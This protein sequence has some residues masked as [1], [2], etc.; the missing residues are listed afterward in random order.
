MKKLLLGL[1]LALPIT[2]NAAISLVAVNSTQSNSAQ[3]R[4][5][6]EPGT[7]ADGDVIFVHCFATQTGTVTWTD[8][9]DFTEINQKATTAGSP[10]QKSYLGYKVRSGG[11]GQ[12]L[13]FSHADTASQ[14]A[15]TQQWYRGVDNASPLDVTFV[16]ASHYKQAAQNSPNT[17]AAAITTN[18]ANSWVILFQ[19]GTQLITGASGPPSGYT[20]DNDLFGTG[21]GLASRLS[22][23]AHK[24][25]AAAGTETPGV[26]THTDTNNTADTR[27]YTIAL[28]AAAAPTFTGA[29]SCS[30]A[31]NGVSCTYTASAASTAYGVGVALGDGAPTCTQIIAGQNDGGTAALATGSDANT[32][33]ADTIVVTG[34]NPIAKMDYYFC[35]SNGGGNSAV[36]SSQSDKLRTARTG[37]AIVTMASHS[38]TGICNEDS[39]FTPDCADPDVFEYEDDT[40]ESADC[41]VSIDTAGD[42]T[43][44]PVVAG[45]CDGRQTFEISYE[46]ASSATTGLFTAPTTGTF[47]TDDTVYINNSAPVCDIQEASSILLLTEDVAM[48]AIDLVV[49]GDCAD[50]DA[51]ALTFTEIGAGTIPTGTAL[52]GTGN[53]DWT[54]TPSA[55]D[56]NGEALT[57]QACDIAGDCDSFD[58]TVYVV[59]TWVVPDLVG[60]TQAAAE[61]AVIAAAPWRALDPGVA[62]IGTECSEETAGTITDQ[63]PDAAAT[64]TGSQDI[65]VILAI[66]CG[67]PATEKKVVFVVTD[68]TGL[69]RWVDYIPVS[70]VPGCEAGRYEED[71]CWAT[72]PLSSTTGKTAWVDYIPVGEVP[73]EP[74]GKWRYENDGWIPVDDLVP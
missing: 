21:L 45:D 47:A 16:E 17:S 30:A 44:T 52:S 71:G 22:Y 14:I 33:S 46:D 54:G 60:S 18:S 48:T 1:I 2:A 24:L 51:D 26:F 8:P 70:E 62:V 20:M 64:A 27:T 55:E 50:A 53:K 13:T 31:A 66:D 59:N 11:A 34:T 35:V 43:L 74:A 5:L 39:Y 72:L 37:F 28:K 68:L 3:S 7:V 57:F 49:V 67:D 41:N 10:T 40:N 23:T 36:D 38:S 63:D 9:S 19:G 4:T 6:T 29:P 25:V 58:L 65:D 42:L 56:E 73:P 69:V 61:T 32:G 12:A 15:C